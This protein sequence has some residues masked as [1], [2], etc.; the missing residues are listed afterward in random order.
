MDHCSHNYSRPL[1]KRPL[2]MKPGLF[3][4]IPTQSD[5]IPEVPISFYIDVGEKFQC[6]CFLCCYTAVTQN[7][8]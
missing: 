3:V 7:Q 2:P 8:N 6:T 1:F 5:I 4:D